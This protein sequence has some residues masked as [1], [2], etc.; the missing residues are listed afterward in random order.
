MGML[1]HQGL[2]MALHRPEACVRRHPFRTLWQR[3]KR[4]TE[5]TP[6]QPYAEM[7]W[8]IWR[9]G[10]S[11]DC[12]WTPSLAMHQWVRR[13]AMRYQLNLSPRPAYR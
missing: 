9:V 1:S 3:I 12:C 8:L 13:P 10:G 6:V 5:C 7:A 2:A 4:G 11:A